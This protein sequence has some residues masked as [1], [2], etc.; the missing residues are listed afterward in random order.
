M[1]NG[2]FSGDAKGHFTCI[3][4]NGASIVDYMKCSSSLFQYVKDFCVME[5]DYSVHFPIKCTMQLPR[6]CNDCKETTIELVT[7]SG[8]LVMSIYFTESSVVYMMNLP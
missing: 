2:R 3:A 8:I 6:K 1:L 4:N 7:I 5:Y